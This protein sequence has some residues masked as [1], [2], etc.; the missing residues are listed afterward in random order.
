[1]LVLAGIDLRVQGTV[2]VDGPA[3]VV[4]NHSS[5]VDALALMLT[6]P[7]T[8]AFVTSS[9]MEHR[10]FI[11]SFLRRL[12]CVFV[13][14]GKAERSAED[15]KAMADLVEAGR[16]L[17]IFPEGSIAQVAGLR[18]FHLGAF[19]V[20]SATG[21]PVIPVGIRG[22]RDILRPGAY[23]PRHAAATVTIGPSIMPGGGGLAGDV[24]LAHRC[25]RAVAEL[26]QQLEIDR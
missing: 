5:F 21:C 3:V 1:M 15:L 14:R 20:A 24:D 26:S 12:G 16:H 4:A 22:T 25:R 6:L 9:D 2:P 8:V 10:R 23:L 7:P 18:P 17:V 19:A 13:H 11:G